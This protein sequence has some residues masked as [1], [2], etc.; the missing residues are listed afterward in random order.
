[1][2]NPITTGRGLGAGYNSKRQHEDEDEKAFHV[3]NFSVN[4]WHIVCCIQGQI[5]RIFFQ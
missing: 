4:L 2:I 3:F 1:M 5:L